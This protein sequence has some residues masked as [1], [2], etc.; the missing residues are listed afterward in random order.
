[1]TITFQIKAKTNK[2][3]WDKLNE[4]LL[5]N[6]PS[7]DNVWYDVQAWGENMGDYFLSRVYITENENKPKNE[8]KD[9]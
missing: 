6:V 9:K 1:M 3:Y 8:P 7:K 4:G 2:E 5:K